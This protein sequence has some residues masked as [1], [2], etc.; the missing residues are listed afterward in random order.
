[1]WYFRKPSEQRIRDFL[2]RQ[3]REPF[4]Y[5]EVGASRE[6]TP[7][8]YD[9][10]HNRVLLGTGQ[11]VFE[12]ASAALRRW[13]MFP[14]PWTRIEPAGAPI[15]EGTVVAMLA[16][17]FC[18]WWLNACRIVYV[19]DEREPVR[20]FGFAYGT[21]PGHVECGEERFS[22]EWHADDTVWYDLRAFSRPRYW[23]VRLAYPLARR[24]QRRFVRESQAAMQRI[25]IGV[26]RRVVSTGP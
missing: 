24:L 7:A 6:G 16:R 18:L 10:D 12:A 1:M 3:E 25:A 4:S 13:E 21:L 23:M 22:I 26:S 5:P 20:R 9:L 11:A 2:A 19:L 15:K 8:G 17:V 14:G